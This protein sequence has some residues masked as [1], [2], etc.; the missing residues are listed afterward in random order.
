MHCF[1]KAKYEAFC[2]KKK[3]CIDTKIISLNHHWVCILVAVSAETRLP[4]LE[5][6]YLLIF[7]CAQDFLGF[8]LFDSFCIALSQY[9]AWV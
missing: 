9:S 5:L 8:S 1:L 6:S 4:L 3:Q 2:G 7:R